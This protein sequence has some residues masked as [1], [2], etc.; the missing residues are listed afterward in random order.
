MWSPCPGPPSFKSDGQREIG[1]GSANL[2]HLRNGLRGLIDALPPG[3]RVTV[4]STAPQPRFIVRETADRDSITKGLG[5]L[6]SAT[7]SSTR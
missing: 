7:P 2:I 5:L 6:G 3:I 1:L 4:V